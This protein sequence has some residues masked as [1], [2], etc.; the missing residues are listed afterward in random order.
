MTAV[1]K[2]IL[3]KL[4]PVLA[5]VFSAALVYGQE[6]IP[7]V[8]GTSLSGHALSLPQD[9]PPGLSVL[10][11]GFTQASGESSKEWGRALYALTQKGGSF[12]YFQTP[13]LTAVPRFIRGMVLGNIKKGVVASQQDRFLPIF[14]HE[15]GWKNAVSYTVPDDSYILVVNQQGIDSLENTRPCDAGANC[16]PAKVVSGRG[17]AI[18]PWIQPSSNP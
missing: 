12:A 9:L 4:M 5:V 1:M 18:R 3:W 15:Q 16:R 2:K 14:D 13:V 8:E 11:I 6:A 7:H 10:V 17:G